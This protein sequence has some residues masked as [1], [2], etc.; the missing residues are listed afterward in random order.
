MD[1]SAEA[2]S[3]MRTGNSHHRASLLPWL[4][5]ILVLACGS[6]VLAQVN[7][8]YAVVLGIEDGV[9]AISDN[10]SCAGTRPVVEV[11]VAAGSSAEIVFSL[12]TA[13]QDWEFSGMRI[14]DPA[15]NWLDP[16][17]EETAADFP[18][19]SANG[20]FRDSMPEDGNLTI[21]DGNGHSLAVQYTITVR[22]RRSGA[23]LPPAHGVI[24]N[25]GG[26]PGPRN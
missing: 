24:D 12:G 16:L 6:A 1:A 3:D 8:R 2:A 7:E 23:E 14:R 26:A 4:A 17:P 22:N 18:Q 10:A 19:F 21:R 13:A 11:C 25:D 5:V 9:M 15:R 20:E